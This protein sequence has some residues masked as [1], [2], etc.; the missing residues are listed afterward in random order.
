MQCLIC[1]KTGLKPEVNSWNNTFF[2]RCCIV[3][4]DM[5]DS[6]DQAVHAYEDFFCNKQLKQLFD[7][8]VKTRLDYSGS[9][10]NLSNERRREVVVHEIL[11]ELGW[12]S[13]CMK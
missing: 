11:S 4:V 8:F 7:A 3:F 2:I 1:S 5:C 9:F 12:D 6:V 10:G 13:Q